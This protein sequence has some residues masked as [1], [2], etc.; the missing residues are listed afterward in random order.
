MKT[1]RQPYSMCLRPG[2]PCRPGKLGSVG[3][4][5]TTPVRRFGKRDC[6]CLQVLPPL[7]LR[8]RRAA[9]AA[10]GTPRITR[11]LRSYRGLR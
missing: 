8:L 4:A 10:P 9:A 7:C 6:L 1:T 5:H 2:V 11:H 3:G